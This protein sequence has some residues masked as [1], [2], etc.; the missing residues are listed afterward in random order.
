MRQAKPRHVLDGRVALVTGASSGIGWAVALGFADA[1]A[2]LI[3]VARRSLRLAQ[4]AQAIQAK[5]R[6]ALLVVADVAEKRAVKRILHQANLEFPRIDVL[7]NNAG[8]LLPE[9]PTHETPVDDWDRVLAVNLRGPFMLS[10]LVVSRMLAAGYG[11]IINVTSQ[12][13]AERNNGAYSASKAALWALTKVMAQELKGTG[14]LVN[15]LDPGWIRSEMSPEGGGPPE[16]VVP[17]ALRLASLPARGPTGREFRVP[18]QEK[19]H[20]RD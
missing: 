5:G 15:A 8:V 16:K 19:N 10:R 14:I 4:L 1:G 7:V 18:W 6:K 12:W 9:Q 13:K 20:G 2:D 11:R 3:L 17:L